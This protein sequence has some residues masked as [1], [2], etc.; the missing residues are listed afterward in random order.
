MRI[1]AAA[2]FVALG[3]HE[4][5]LPKW[6]LNYKENKQRRTR[7]TQTV[8]LRVSVCFHFPQRSLLTLFVGLP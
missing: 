5:Q 8:F 6:I 4:Q 2:A 7:G 1:V 3:A